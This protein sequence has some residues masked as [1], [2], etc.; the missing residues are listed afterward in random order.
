MEWGTAGM[1]TFLCM[2]IMLWL[3]HIHIAVPKHGILN[4][5]GICFLVAIIQDIK[6]CMR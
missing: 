4:F 5:I 1:R 3:D 6:E 2:V